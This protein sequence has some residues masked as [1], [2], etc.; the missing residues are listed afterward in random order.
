MKWI[1]YILNRNPKRT[2]TMSGETLRALLP[3]PTVR[4]LDRSYRGTSIQSF[5]KF[6]KFDKTSD[7]EYV[8][9]I[10]DCDDFA[11]AF[12]V[13]VRKWAPGIPVGIV[14]GL[15]RDRSP[16][17]WNCFVD[18]QTKEMYYFEPQDDILFKHTTE[19]IWE[20]II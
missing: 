19:N 6:A 1:D 12:F 8:P 5:M 7:E 16:H 10:T 20:I 13:A 9:E 14:I 11:F 18:T 17:A 15:A 2:G 4:V 3:T